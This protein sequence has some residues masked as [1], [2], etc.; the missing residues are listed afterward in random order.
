MQIFNL[1][2]RLT[3]DDMLD[4]ARLLVKAGYAAGLGT[5]KP[6][7]KKAMRHIEYA[8]NVRDSAEGEESGSRT[9]TTRSAAKGAAASA[10]DKTESGAP[11]DALEPA[12]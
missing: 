2:G 4:M 5:T 1:S 11:C 7:G 3:T 9:R 6:D 10:T 12:T 8:V